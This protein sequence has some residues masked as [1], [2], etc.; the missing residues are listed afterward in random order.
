MS[1]VVGAAASA[2]GTRYA[3]IS[4]TMSG[5]MA[6]PVMLAGNTRS[7][8]A[9]VAL[10]GVTS[11]APATSTKRTSRVPGSALRIAQSSWPSMSSIRARQTTTSCRF[12]SSIVSAKEPLEA[13]VT[14]A[15][16]AVNVSLSTGA[17]RRSGST[18][19]T[20]T[21][22]PPGRRAGRVIR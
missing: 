6:P 21:A 22:A 5:R 15:P 11:S 1:M 9:A 14:S 3:R 8:P 7:T 2:A 17:R 4:R 12:H 16:P 13:T 20:F 19:K 10:A 18:T